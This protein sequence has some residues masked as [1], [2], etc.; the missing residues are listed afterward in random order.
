MFN[1]FFFTELRYTLKQPM[2]YI[3]L[4]IISLLVFG[5][6]ASDSVTI[7]GSVGNV[8]KNAP[9]IISIF[10]TIMSIF[11]LLIGVAFFN[12]AALRDYNN[13]FNEIIF[14]TPLSK[15]GYFFG[16][17]FGAL[18]VST[19]PMLGVF[20]GVII[21]TFLAPILGWED[22]DRFGEFYLSAFVNNYLLFVL[23]NMF[24]AGA[25]IYSMAIT[26]RSTII[27]FVGALIIIVAYLVSGTLMSDL[28][29][30][31]MGALADTFGIRTYGLITKYYTPIEKN[32]LSPGFSG[33]LLINRLV[34]IA[35]GGLILLGTY[36]RFS[37]LEKSKKVKK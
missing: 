19:I 27:S 24:F 28:D 34:W 22:V 32:T 11:G 12:N 25:I 37:F 35:I 8:V 17:F 23:P 21:G 18:I 3:F 14:S 16:R 10:T 5:A 4:V 9:Y 29:N 13:N 31:T 36:F 20:I 26:W 15:P 30:E 33:L 6:T 7:G 2:V 1:T